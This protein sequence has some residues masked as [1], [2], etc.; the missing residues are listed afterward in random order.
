VSVPELQG[1]VEDRA[2]QQIDH[3]LTDE[4]R[5]ALH[6]RPVVITAANKAEAIATYAKVHDI[7]VIV[8]GTHGRGAIGHLFMGSVAEH[9]VRT[10][11]CPVLTVHESQRQCIVPDSLVAVERA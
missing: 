9:V 3:L 4:D 5:A 7:D 6:A 8:M 11:T 10:A 1:E 2:Q